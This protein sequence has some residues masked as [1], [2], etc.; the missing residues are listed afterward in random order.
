M[1]CLL[2]LRTTEKALILHRDH[3]LQDLLGNLLLLDPWQ[4]LHPA[5][6]S[7]DFGSGTHVTCA[8]IALEAPCC[9][10]WVKGL[11][12]APCGKVHPSW[13]RQWWQTAL[14]KIWTVKRKQ[15]LKKI[16]IH[17]QKDWPY[18]K[19]CYWICIMYMYKY[20]HLYPSSCPCWKS[21]PSL[22][23]AEGQLAKS[24][25]PCWILVTFLSLPRWYLEPACSAFRLVLD[26]S[27]AP[28]HDYHIH[29]PQRV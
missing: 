27:T 1:M 18:R 16:S 20:L 4:S 11:H 14:R 19:C 8:S 5:L 21:S 23:W 9:W 28:L 6:Q 24:V 2:S 22:S 29:T 25:F 15:E 7:T 3:H 12:W 17:H 26:C 13:P 10:L